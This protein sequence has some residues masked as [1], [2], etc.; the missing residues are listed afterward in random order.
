MVG[1]LVDRRGGGAR[2][3]ERP[4]PH[5]PGRGDCETTSV[6]TVLLMKA[7]N[8]EHSTGQI[9]RGLRP[10]DEKLENRFRILIIKTVADPFGFSRPR[11]ITHE[12]PTWFERVGA[13]VLAMLGESRA[14]SLPKS[15]LH[16]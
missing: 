11:P 3:S 10:A 15:I 9:R 5:G 12:A 2:F 8:R 13:S 4:R 6:A 7:R 1:R 14:S 16:T